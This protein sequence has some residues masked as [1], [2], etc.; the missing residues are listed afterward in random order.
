M[1]V[2]VCEILSSPVD[3]SAHP[4]VLSPILLRPVRSFSAQ[5]NFY[6]VPGATEADEEQLSRQ[7]T[8]MSFT[9]DCTLLL[10]LLL[11][12]AARGAF[13][14]LLPPTGNYQ[15]TCD[16]LVQKWHCSLIGLASGYVQAGLCRSSSGEERA[17]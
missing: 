1:C 8:L 7:K 16:P 6:G 17:Q 15:C 10:L 11:S 14:G 2:F 12:A 13:V 4:L 9:I 5:N 3:S